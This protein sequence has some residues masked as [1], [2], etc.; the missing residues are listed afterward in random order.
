MTAPTAADTAVGLVSF[1]YILTAQLRDG[2]RA[3]LSDVI[4]A[5]PARVS[6]ADLYQH[7]REFAARK[8]GYGA[9]LVLFF[10]LER[11]AL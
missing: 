7:I 6:R 5:D 9:F 8:F 3:T 1:H 2:D 10:S 4:Q 11:N